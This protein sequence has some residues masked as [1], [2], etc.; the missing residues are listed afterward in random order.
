M[1]GCWVERV[2]GGLSNEDKASKQ[3]T[4]SGRVAKIS[5]VK[6]NDP[7]EALRAL[8]KKLA[9]LKNLFAVLRKARVAEVTNRV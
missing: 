9:W 4:C 3:D 5:P 7:P 6:C 2:R 8:R 1:K